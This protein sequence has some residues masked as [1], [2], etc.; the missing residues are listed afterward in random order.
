[1]SNVIVSTDLWTYHGVTQKL[2][3]SYKLNANV[4]I[5][6]AIF[7]GPSR[8]CRFHGYLSLVYVIPG[9]TLGK[10]LGVMVAGELG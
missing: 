5:V 2:S 3:K 1:M 10:P 4:L 6:F 7:E 9:C 8:P